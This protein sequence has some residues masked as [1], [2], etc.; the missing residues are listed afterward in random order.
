MTTHRKRKTVGPEEV[1]LLG[2]L[3]SG[4]IAGFEKAAGMSMHEMELRMRAAG[5][6][7]ELG[8][9]DEFDPEDDDEFYFDDDDDED[10][11]DDDR[12]LRPEWLHPDCVN[13]CTALELGTCCKYPVSPLV[14]RAVDLADSAARISRE[15][16]LASVPGLLAQVHAV[17]PGLDRTAV[18]QLS[19][20]VGRLAVAA[21]FGPR[22][23]SEPLPTLL[24]LLD[25]CAHA[26]WAALGTVG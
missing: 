26:L 16:L 15:R 8:D 24:P 22:P 2:L 4:D 10:E 13:P 18:A 1:R 5:E 14:R 6:L 21:E 25:A 20:P 7:G 12:R 3:L 11:D 19:C 9:E 23:E 17:L